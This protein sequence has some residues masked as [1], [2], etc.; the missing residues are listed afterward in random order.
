MGNVL[1]NEASLQDIANAIR[2]KTESTDKFLPSQ[3]A[4][5]V[6]GI[7]SGEGD[8]TY[9]G[10]R[11]NEGTVLVEN[12]VEVFVNHNSGFIPEIFILYPK[13]DVT[14][15]SANEE[16]AFI[17]YYGNLLG[18]V[19]AKPFRFVLEN[20][21]SY[22]SSCAWFEASSGISNPTET[23]IRIPYRSSAYPF[24]VA[25]YGWIAI[26]EEIQSGGGF[27]P[28]DYCYTYTNLFQNAEFPSDSSIEMYLP[29]ASTAI[30]SSVFAFNGVF[31]GT[32]GLKRIKIS[33][34]YNGRTCSI[35][36]FCHSSKIVEVDFSDW[37]LPI[38]DGATAFYN[39]IVIKRIIGELEFSSD[40]TNVSNMFFN[41]KVLEEV[42]FKK[43]TLPLSMSLLYSPNLSDASIDSLVNGFADMTGQTAIVFTVHKD[44]KARIEANEVW[45]AT[46]TSKNVTLA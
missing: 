28:L 6:R 19:Y 17:G 33:T 27:N 10:L 44:V 13:F 5:A 31:N 46:L 30:S 18:G 43:E 36:A 2:E 38:K 22:T 16:V 8:V 15:G 24:R 12:G 32:K 39:N 26:S 41:C 42:R 4:D 14:V 35:N 3:M 45:L 21:T 20:R 40:V 23:R 34:P 37:H 25:E 9:N 7:I 29:R 11:Y 1:V